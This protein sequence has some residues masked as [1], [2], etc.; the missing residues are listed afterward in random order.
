[1]TPRER[2]ERHNAYLHPARE[3]LAEQPVSF[4]KNPINEERELERKKERMRE[5]EG[6]EED[7]AV[8]ARLVLS[9]QLR[10]RG[11]FSSGFSHSHCS[12]SVEG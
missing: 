3:M 4:P 6:K 11:N 10:D 7:D 8:H 5:R 2:V 1:M 12:G 9:I